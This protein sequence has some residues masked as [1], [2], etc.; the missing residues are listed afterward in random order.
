L[1]GRIRAEPGQ[2]RAETTPGAA[3]RVRRG[4]RCLCGPMVTTDDGVCFDFVFVFDDGLGWT[5]RRVWVGVAYGVGSEFDDG[6]RLG[7]GGAVLGLGSRGSRNAGRSVSVGGYLGW[8]RGSGVAEP[9]TSVLDL[10]WRGGLVLRLG[11]R[12]VPRGFPPRPAKPLGLGVGNLGARGVRDRPRSGRASHLG[13]SDSPGRPICRRLPV[14]TA[15]KVL[16]TRPL[17]P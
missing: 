16:L 14:G 8:G 12:G 3:R 1:T 11:A 9:P 5:G 15:C 10:R 4:P 6:D 2:R 13:S 17:N 7:D